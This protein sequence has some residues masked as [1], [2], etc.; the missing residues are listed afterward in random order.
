MELLIHLNREQNITVITSLHQV[1][2]VKRYFNR[3]IA[4]QGGEV[5]FD[6]RTIDLDDAQL[7]QVYGSAT[8][9]LVLSG[10]GEFSIH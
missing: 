10:H 7:N 1:Q 4:L 5:K 3:A 6:G 2:M 9:E 8:E